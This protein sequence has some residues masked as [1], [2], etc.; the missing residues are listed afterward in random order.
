ME[1]AGAGKGRVAQQRE[2]EVTRRPRTRG[3]SC[4]D[5]FTQAQEPPNRIEG[6][7]DK[8]QSRHEHEKEP[9]AAALT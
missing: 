2:T 5:V 3:G 4:R 6:E 1:R 8:T 9:T 7:H